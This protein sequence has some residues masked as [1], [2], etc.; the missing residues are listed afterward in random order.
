VA[1]A[2]SI[3]ITSQ[4]LA[5]GILETAAIH[6]AVVLLRARIDPA[7]GG[8]RSADHVVYRLPAV[9]GDADQNLARSPGIG[10][11]FG[12]ELAEFVVSQQHGVDGL[13]KHHAGRGP[14]AELLILLGADGLI[15]GGGAGEVGDRQ[16][17]EDQFGHG[18]SFSAGFDRRTNG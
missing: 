5:V 13:G 10:D 4:M 6:E 2:T 7:A 3:H 16:I 1:A 14:V 8:L 9:G 17:D 11:L 12:R 18:S 15:E